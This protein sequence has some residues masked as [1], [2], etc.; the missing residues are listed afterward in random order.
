MN[1]FR[2]RIVLAV[3]LAASS[4]LAAAPE[5]PVAF[6]H[7]DWMRVLERF[8]DDRGLVDYVGLAGDREIFDR[9]LR[10]IA[11]SSPDSEP[12]RFP[13]TEDALAFYLNAYN[14]LVFQGVL[15]RGP[16]APKV[17]GGLVPGY[18]FFVR[19]RVTVGGERTNLK[20]LEDDVVR[21]RFGDPRVHAALNCASM[22]CP[23]LPRRA[24]EGPT[25]DQALDAAMREFVNDERHCRVDDG[26]R[27]IYLSKI[28]DWF[29]S[30]FVEGG[31]AQRGLVDYV[32]RYRPPGDKLPRDY[33]VRFPGYDKRLN[34]Q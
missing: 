26:E 22:G 5:S 30:D 21:A 27:T 12:E 15:D 10:A 23:R 19:M 8:V 34:R 24:F 32:N 28:F 29:S 6:D 33:R 4:G 16:E 1:D 9:Y 18:S 13:T 17:W 2:P 14:A 31:D 3:C 25:L 20:S 7:S 11:T